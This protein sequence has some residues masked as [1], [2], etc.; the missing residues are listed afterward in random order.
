M[1][2][3]SNPSTVEDGKAADLSFKLVRRLSMGIELYFVC[4]L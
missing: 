4:N 2:E 3:I 1:N